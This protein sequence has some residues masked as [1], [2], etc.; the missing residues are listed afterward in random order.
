ML[1]K[2]LILAVPVKPRA[3]EKLFELFTNK[4]ECLLLNACL[5]EHQATAINKHIK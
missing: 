3:L 5:S 2:I 1:T 4:I